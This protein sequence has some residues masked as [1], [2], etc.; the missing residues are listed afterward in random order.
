MLLFSEFDLFC[1][2]MRPTGLYN[3]SCIFAAK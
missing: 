3:L 1:F 2:Y